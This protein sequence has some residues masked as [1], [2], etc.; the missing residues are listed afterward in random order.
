MR[1][2]RVKSVMKGEF[3]M[4]LKKGFI[5]REVGDE[6]VAVPSDEIFDMNLMITLNDTGCFL[7]KLLERE[8]TFENMVSAVLDEYN[9]EVS[10]AENYI[11][12]FIG[13]LDENGFLE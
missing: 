5:L 11:K 12:K 13:T 6:I 8:T 9:I 10:D 3:A 2:C 4:K 7:W 1:L